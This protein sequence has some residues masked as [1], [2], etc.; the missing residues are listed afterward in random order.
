VDQLN[1]T[2]RDHSHLIKAKE[3]TVFIVNS[4]HFADFLSNI[5]VDDASFNRF[6]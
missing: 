6:K 3:N 1:L 2:E 5:E 4:S